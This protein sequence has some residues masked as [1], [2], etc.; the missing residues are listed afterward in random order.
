MRAIHSA[1]VRGISTPASGQLGVVEVS[2][3]HEEARAE[4]T[5]YSMQSALVIMVEV[6]YERE[7]HRIYCFGAKRLDLFNGPVVVL[8]LR[9]R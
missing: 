8:Q 5:R 1:Q 2:N 6:F 4:L 7:L 3:L 9:A